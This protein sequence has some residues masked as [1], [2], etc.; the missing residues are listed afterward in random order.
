[1]ALLPSGII[2]AT[3]G[4]NAAKN[5]PTEVLGGVVVG[6]TDATDVKTGN[7]VTEVF[8][9]SAQAIGERDILTTPKELTSANSTSNNQK[10]LSAGTFAFNQK[11]FMIKM[12]ADK[13][14]NI[15][16]TA[17]SIGGYPNQPPH[18]QTSN[19]QKGAK[20]STAWRAGYW[21]AVGIAGQRTN[22]S[23]APSSNNVNYYTPT[24]GIIAD[25]NAQF[26]LYKAVPGELTYMDG[27]PNPIQDEYKG[28]YGAGL[29]R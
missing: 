29:E 19:K 25:D 7:P 17:L 13:I 15:A 24:G 22:W 9:F 10:A 1:M 16:S 26:V 21:R 11:Q 12:V 2:V 27:S 18:R 4:A 14:N 3:K 23:V 28:R 20:T 6:I 5:S 8:Q